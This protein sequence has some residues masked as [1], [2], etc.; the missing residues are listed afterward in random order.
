MGTRVSDY[1]ESGKAK[2]LMG[3]R[4]PGLPRAAGRAQKSAR[5]GVFG[6]DTFVRTM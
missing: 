6:F 3:R 5:K 2:V 4:A 1:C